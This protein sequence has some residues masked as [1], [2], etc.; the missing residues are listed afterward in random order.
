[1]QTS[2]LTEVSLSWTSVWDRKVLD[3][4]R[5]QEIWSV[6]TLQWTNFW[7]LVQMRKIYAHYQRPIRSRRTQKLKVMRPQCRAPDKSLQLQL[8]LVWDGFAVYCLLINANVWLNS[9]IVNH[10][11]WG[12][13]KGLA[14][15]STFY[16]FRELRCDSQHSQWW[17]KT[18][19]NSSSRGSNVFFWTPE[20]S[21]TDVMHRCIYKQNTHM[22]NKN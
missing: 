17:L 9:V 8:I 19:F 22:Q 13:W 14:D 20:A 11:T 1:M 7:L 15:K 10:I 5:K 4:R 16:S 21:G 18:T 12:W 6:S 2:V 3:V